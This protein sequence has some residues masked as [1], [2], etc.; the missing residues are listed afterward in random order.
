M[1]K[2][3]IEKMQAIVDAG[4]GEMLGKAVSDFSITDSD[5][6]AVVVAKMQTKV[7]EAEARCS[8]DARLVDRAV[9]EPSVAELVRSTLVANLQRAILKKALS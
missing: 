4:C 8:F 3:N 9:S 1:N 6:V 7:G 5:G 2:E